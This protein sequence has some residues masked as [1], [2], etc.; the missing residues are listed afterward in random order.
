MWSTLYGGNKRDYSTSIAV[1]RKGNPVICGLTLSSDLPARDGFMADLPTKETA[2]Y[3]TGF[4]ARFSADGSHRWSTYYGGEREDA[5]YALAIDATGA[6]AITGHTYSY[7]LPV[8][9][10]ALQPALNPHPEADRV[11]TADIFVTKFDSSG[12]F[13]W[14][15]YY[16]SETTDDGWDIAIGPD[17]S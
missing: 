9:A 11:I 1:D 15:T 2:Y 6:I 10:D 8:S 16:G 13:R 12:N 14:G 17:N 5:V 3:Y 7:H 4:V